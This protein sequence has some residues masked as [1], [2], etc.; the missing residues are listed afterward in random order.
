MDNPRLPFFLVAATVWISLE[1]SS[2]RVFSKDPNQIDLGDGRSRPTN[3]QLD[4]AARQVREKAQELRDLKI[5]GGFGTIANSYDDLA[6][7][8]EAMKLSGSGGSREV[9]IP[10]YSKWFESDRAR[11]A[12]PALAGEI[13]GHLDRAMAEADERIREINANAARQMERDSSLIRRDAAAAAGRVNRAMNDALAR[14]N[15]LDRAEGRAVRPSGPASGSLSSKRPQPQGAR[16]PD[17]S[18]I[19]DYL[20]AGSIFYTDEALQEM[21]SQ[22]DGLVNQTLDGPGRMKP[23][24]LDSFQSGRASYD[25]P[26][27]GVNDPSGPFAPGNSRGG[28][29]SDAQFQGPRDTI[30]SDN[31]GTRVIIDEGNVNAGRKPNFG[32]FNQKVSDMGYRD[33]A[34]LARDYDWAKKLVQSSATVDRDLNRTNLELEQL[35]NALNQSKALSIAAIERYERGVEGSSIVK[36]F[37]DGHG[38]FKA[39]RELAESAGEL[40][41]E[42]ASYAFG[43]LKSWDVRAV[44]NLESLKNFYSNRT[45]DLLNLMTSVARGGDSDAIIRQSEDNLERAKKESEEMTE[46]AISGANLL[47]AKRDFDESLDSFKESLRGGGSGVSGMLPY[48]EVWHQPSASSG[49]P[50][51]MTDLQAAQSAR[52]E[53]LL[54]RKKELEAIKSQSSAENLERARQTKSKIEDSLHR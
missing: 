11:I 36:A 26:G 54:L 3:E 4:A 50:K 27:S 42:S 13:A 41:E 18:R 23:G 30:V 8:M 37:R 15:E 45:S 38:V 49:S 20:G 31:S 19:I 53:E 29:M 43:R 35:E 32:P 10:D 17:L 1:F 47:K 28:S 34:E 16:G 33:P 5:G 48:K 51:V 52:R 2:I 39:G 44:E 22:M 21:Q 46:K 12:A 14:L 24:D 25:L 7:R 6:N 40:L 9:W